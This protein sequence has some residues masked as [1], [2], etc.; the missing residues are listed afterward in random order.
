MTHN[1]HQVPHA[2]NFLAIAATSSNLRNVRVRQPTASIA[3]KRVVHTT[4][5]DEEWE[6][7]SDTRTA[8]QSGDHQIHVHAPHT[9]LIDTEWDLQGPSVADK[10]E[11]AEVFARPP[12][13]SII[14]TEWDSQLEASVVTHPEP[15]RV[16]V[17]PQQITLLDMG[18]LEEKPDPVITY[19]ELDDPEYLVES[20][21]D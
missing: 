2:A 11:P 18:D 16:F 4:L 7:Q 20:E 14:D 8:H 17:L 9:S 19:F 15:A 3:A 13:T 1:P 12:H 5:I 6:L 10:L 21:F